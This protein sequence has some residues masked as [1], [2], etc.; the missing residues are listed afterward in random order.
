MRI[1]SIALLIIIGAFAFNAA[2]PATSSAHS[3]GHPATTIEASEAVAVALKHV[4]LLVKKGKIEKSWEE[5]DDGWGKIKKF[6]KRNEWV[7]T[8][9][10][11]RANDPAKRTLYFFFSLKGDYIAANFTGK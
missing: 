7:V 4:K 3:G 9:K 2:C 10:N 1:V 5:V 6:G 8:L 11:S